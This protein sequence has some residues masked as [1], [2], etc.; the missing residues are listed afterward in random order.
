MGQHP[1]DEAPRPEGPS[2]F[3]SL[4]APAPELF[5]PSPT[6]GSTD[7]G[8]TPERVHAPERPGAEAV[9]PADE[10]RADTGPAPEAA[11]NG[12]VHD[13]EISS[14]T[15]P[16]APR[17]P[18]PTPVEET[19]RADTPAWQVAPAPALG[20]VA[21]APDPTPTDGPA[22]DRIA[23]PSS[24]GTPASAPAPSPAP[25]PAPTG[26]E[27]RWREDA[28]A[29]APA[30]DVFDDVLWPD[31]A[32]PESPWSTP[33]RGHDATPSPP[34]SPVPP[35]E[36]RTGNAPTSPDDAPGP[37]P[38][39]PPSLSSAPAPSAWPSDVSSRPA[40]IVPPPSFVRPDPPR[41]EPPGDSS[42]SEA[43]RASRQISAPPGS[44]GNSAPAST[45]WF[46]PPHE[47]VRPTDGD[48]SIDRDADT[49]ADDSHT[50]WPPTAE[51]S[52]V[53]A[54]R[55]VQEPPD[56]PDSR[57]PA[58]PFTAPEPVT[59]SEP[60][61]APA[62]LTPPEPVEPVTAP[63]PFATPGPFTAP[64]PVAPP[65]PFATPAALTAPEPRTTPERFDTSWP[66]ATPDSAGARDPFAAPEPFGTP[67]RDAAT[68]PFGPQD[69]PDT[70]APFANHDPVGAPS[71]EPDAAGPS[72]SAPA[73]G[74]SGD[75][76]A[77]APAASADDAHPLAAE[78]TGTSASPDADARTVTD[79]DDGSDEPGAASPSDGDSPFDSWFAPHAPVPTR[80]PVTTSERP[81]SPFDAPGPLDDPH[82]LGD[83][84]AAP[85][86]RPAPAGPS[87][88]DAR[89]AT[90]DA[91]WPPADPTH[92]HV[93]ERPTREAPDEPEPANAAASRRGGTAARVLGVLALVIGLGA[94][95]AAIL[96]LTSAWSWIP[97]VVA[98][99]LGVIALVRRAAPRF[100]AVAGTVLGPVA[101]AIAVLVSFT[102]VFDAIAGTVLAGTTPTPEP[103]TVET[104]EPEAPPV[105][106]DV[107][108]EGVGS[109]VLPIQ[110]IDGLD[111][112][113]IV[114]VSATEAEVP[115]EVWSL[116]SAGQR[117]EKLVDALGPYDGTVAFDAV[118]PPTAAPDAGTDSGSSDDV[119]PGDQTSGDVSLEIITE[120]A[121]TVTIRSI[122]ALETFGDQTSGTSGTSDTVLR[123][124]GPGGIATIGYTGTG[125][126][127]VRRY[128]E[129]TE[130]LLN[131]IGAYEGSVNWPSG[132]SLVTVR[133]A[134][135]WTITVA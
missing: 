73:A 134:G 39:D 14:E 115:L 54:P 17:R 29:V 53:G 102:A 9:A 59:P 41:L 74:G 8:V 117:L 93:P 77:A 38:E 23:A 106:A 66:P 55:T 42:S 3:S 51:A 135:P 13:D 46:G 57:P 37:P 81:P 61:A 21:G 91:T 90:P 87:T 40:T 18:D 124:D 127:S 52:S 108:H 64:E 111:Q 122:E 69:F 80:R 32:A 109:A 112:P 4:A 86:W 103:T 5:G 26:S 33:T 44:G 118:P 43:D 72:A 105:P 133:A 132:A 83:S 50:W 76:L 96:P 20:H 47:T 68:G 89:A 49:V 88:S 65:E 130:V 35:F 101:L 82:A 116:G 110:P 30:A 28:D 126:F 128:A 25:T 79:A 100:P 99:I 98:I 67:G 60:F 16:R 107:V 24:A 97:A 121:W 125:S 85:E 119:T 62:A 27:R 94:V 92:E 131:T 22:P 34:G 48:R 114:L 129:N 6:T 15:I 45:T 104:Q 120:G 1:E 63:E 78:P 12:P 36:E 10:P 70:R 113:I 7:D 95:G 75:L 31:A 123:Y 11:G 56:A 58:G 84:P 71:R 19:V 2:L